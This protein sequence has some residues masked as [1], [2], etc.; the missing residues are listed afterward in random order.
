MVSGR[1]YPLP[2][3]YCWELDPSNYIRSVKAQKQKV[4]KFA[5]VVH[6]MKAQLQGEIDLEEGDIVRIVEIVDRDWYRGQISD[7]RCGIFPSSFVRIV[8]AFPGSGPD[9]PGAA[10]PYL[11]AAKHKHNEYMNTK[12]SFK[13]L[14]EGLKTIGQQSI[15]N[16]VINGIPES[17]QSGETH[18]DLQKQKQHNSS[19]S[20]EMF[21][22]DYFRRN[23]PA[24]SYGSVNSTVPPSEVEY[25]PEES[26][27]GSSVQRCS[28]GFQ[29]WAWGEI[30]I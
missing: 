10:R 16:S 18:P 30:Q 12:H 1:T 13:G 25:N 6:S 2:P 29:V 27:F 23:L 17:V 3:S 8:D 15:L 9:N 20:D 24:S 7:G 22:D 4:E 28:Q 21:Q 5:K 26:M 19:S 14:E 11:E